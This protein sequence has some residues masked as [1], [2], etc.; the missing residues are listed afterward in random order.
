MA[1][2]RLLFLSPRLDQWSFL[3]VVTLLAWSSPLS[4]TQLRRIVRLVRT[5]SGAVG[6]GSPDTRDP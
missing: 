2:L 3:T 4:R 1:G 6:A 5:V